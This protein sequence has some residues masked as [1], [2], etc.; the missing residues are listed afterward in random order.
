MR[1]RLSMGDRLERI[2]GGFRKSLAQ[3][4]ELND[5]ADREV[6][7]ASKEVLDAQIKKEDAVLLAEKISKITGNFSTLLGEDTNG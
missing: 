5:A 3:L 6:L 2:L 4:E 7:T 1:L